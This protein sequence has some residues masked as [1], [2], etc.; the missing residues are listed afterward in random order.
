MFNKSIV[1]LA[2]LATG[3][4]H[5]QTQTGTVS[6]MILDSQ[7]GRPI[8]GAVLLADGD[9]SRKVVTDAQGNY[10]LTL[11]AGTHQ[12]T[13]T[14]AEYHPV[15]LTEVVV[16]AGANTEASTVM[17]NKSVVTTVDVVA[18][19]TAVGA[20][21]EAV[22]QERKLSAVVSD[23][24]G[25]E[26]LSAGTASDAAGALQK[27]T[28]VSVVGSGFVYVRGLGERY[29]ATE[30]NG[31]VVPTTEPEKRV[32][33]LDLFPA[34]LIDN[35][36]IAKTYTPETPAE[37]S[38][39]LV[40]MKTVEFPPR[41]TFSLSLK[42]GYNT[43]S[44]FNPFLTSPAGTGDFFGFGSGSRGLPGII[45]R[46]QRLFRGKF[47]PSELQTFG[48]AFSDNWEPKYDSQARPAI[49]WSG[50]GGASFGRLGVVGAV[51]FSNKPSL[52]SETQRYIRQGFEGPIVFTE[53]KDYKEYEESARLGGVFNTS[54]R[55]APNHSFSLQNTYTHEGEKTSRRFSGYDGGVDS[56]V[57]GE[58]LRYIERSLYSSA[59]SGTHALP[60]WH[61]GLIHWQFTFSRSTRDEPDLRE[62]IRNLLPNGTY[63]FSASGSSGFRFFS[64]LTDKIYD[65]QVDYSTPFAEGRFS[66]L[67]KVGVR[68]SVRRRDFSARRFLFE[69]QQFTTLNLLAPSNQLFAASNIRPTGFQITEFTRATDS[70]NA[71][72]NVYSGYA[73]LDLNLGSKWRLEG[74]FRVEDADQNVITYDNRVPNA[75]PVTA[76]L[77]N[78][79]VVPAANLIYA[80]T[81]RQNLRLSY[82]R[83]LSRPDFRELSPFDF[84]NVLGGFVTA[85]NPELKRA[86]IDNFDA[87]WEW[88][89]G[90]NQLVAA[91]FFLKNF[92]DPI[93][94]TIVP[95]N[96]LRQTFV[97]AKG[98][99]NY[100]MELEFRRS[101]A[102][103]SQRLHEFGVSANLTL[104]TSSIE[105]RP[106]DATIITSASRPLLGQS[107]AIVNGVFQWTRAK[108]RSDA[109]FFAN[110][111]SRRITDVG[112]F[113][114]PD[115][116]QE[117]NT[118]LDFAYTYTVDEEGKWNI[119]F[120]AENLGDNRYRWTQGPFVQREYRLGRTFQVGFNYSFL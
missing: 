1:L 29:S 25:H 10:Q 104:V 117:G 50:V 55:L 106:E 67:F 83:T 109:K 6:G 96:D 31:A 85:G 110:F 112:T 70:Y 113:R 3:L 38:G 47:T 40:Q 44:T 114:V 60:D 94:Q 4:T 43:V 51:S 69:P 65:P 20:T 21:A 86:S 57:A 41:R 102:T 91:S 119:R 71:E 75:K 111:V 81:A 68:A 115:I 64:D 118:T 19:A 84:S 37:F 82:S 39:G 79:D 98:A 108:W 116:Y 11:Q 101:L 35:I 92:T 7:S 15:N 76:G 74:G 77:H 30:L 105:I 14:A 13:I 26:E 103:I 46:D 27:V 58:R 95:S 72:M 90:G 34:G 87:R 33:P 18:S 8:V 100:G 78:R 53:Y 59:L 61:N 24:I 42:S 17:A 45:P 32:V 62:V 9:D 73:M 97:N 12:L 66:G 52:L 2:L 36:K 16:K 56:Y 5:A 49:D 99:R 107:R 54:Y 89:S 22:L 28:G 63:S 93:E 120:E 88:F 48:Q 23:S 80:L